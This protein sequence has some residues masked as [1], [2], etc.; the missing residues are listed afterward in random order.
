M[1]LKATKH[2]RISVNKRMQ[3]YNKTDGRCFYCCA[4]LEIEDMLDWGG[5]VVTQRHHWEVDHIIPLQGENVCGLHVDY[6]LQYLTPEENGKK[7]NRLYV[8]LS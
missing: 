3:V 1:N 6:N 5:K 2:Y 7:G 8:E 4:I